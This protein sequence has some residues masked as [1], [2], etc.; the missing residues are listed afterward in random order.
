VET[1]ALLLI[2]S[3]SIIVEPRTVVTESDEQRRRPLYEGC[4]GE[5]ARSL[6]TQR[7]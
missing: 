5:A 3:A 6:D 7:E 4:V 2:L 1:P